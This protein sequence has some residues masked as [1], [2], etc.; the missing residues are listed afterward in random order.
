VLHI[1]GDRIPASIPAYAHDG[2]LPEPL[3]ETVRSIVTTLTAERQTG[4]E[5]SAENG[6]LVRVAREDGPNG[7]MAVFVHEYKTRDGIKQFVAQYGI[8][9]REHEV[10][11]MLI[12]GHSTTA[13]AER[14]NV[15][16]STVLLHIKSLLVKT[17]SHSRTELV[18]K[19]V[20]HEGRSAILRGATPNQL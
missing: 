17:R 6:M 20:L 11:T 12:D 13:M 4:L 3:R 15:A 18:G 7:N 2:K 9:P 1:P 16:V 8:T 10:L 5:I 19:V 14:I